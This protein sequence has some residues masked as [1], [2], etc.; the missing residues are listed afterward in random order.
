LGSRG[1]QSWKWSDFVG[2]S[3]KTRASLIAGNDG[4]ASLAIL[5]EGFPHEAFLLTDNQQG[6]V[7]AIRDPN[8]NDRIDLGYTA[9][10][11]SLAVADDNGTVRAM[12]GEQGDLTFKKGGQI[13]WASFGEDMTPEERKHVMDLLNQTI[14]P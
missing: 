5:K 11:A 2:P 8:G 10:K 7:L 1:W 3:G 6:K 13:D 4:T 12:V 14:Q 9:K